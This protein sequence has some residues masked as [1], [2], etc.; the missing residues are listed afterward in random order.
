MSVKMSQCD[1]KSQ[2]C[3][4]LE[5]NKYSVFCSHGQVPHGILS[6]HS[7]PAI[8]YAHISDI[9]SFT[10]TVKNIDMYYLII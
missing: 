3:L 5:H 8:K 7:C 6:P 1:I 4:Q 2:L 9:Y 10:A